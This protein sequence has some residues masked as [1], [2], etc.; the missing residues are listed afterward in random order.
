MTESAWT[1]RTKSRLLLLGWDADA[2]DRGVRPRGQQLEI[3]AVGE[4]VAATVSREGFMS[5]LLATAREWCQPATA[6]DPGHRKQSIHVQ[7]VFAI[8]I[9]GVLRSLCARGMLSHLANNGA[10][11]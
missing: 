10:L 6:G 1:P 5:A 3:D 9:I 11:R 8:V 4:D 7:S 2:T